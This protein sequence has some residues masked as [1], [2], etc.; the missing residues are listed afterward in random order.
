VSR[1]VTSAPFTSESSSGRRERANVAGHGT[2]STLATVSEPDPYQQLLADLAAEHA[3]LDAVVAPLEAAAW[4]TP[5]PAEGW[6]VAD[7]ISH[8]HFFDAAATRAAVD[9][10]G[11]QREVEQAL[12]DP[13]YVDK[14]LAAGRGTAP[15]ELL[16]SW[17]AGRA[18]MLDVFGGLDGKARLPWYGPPMSAMSFA[19]ARLMETWAHGQDVVDAVGAERTPTDRLRHVAHLGVRTRGFSYVVRGLEPP[20]DDVRV[21]LV[22]PSG[23][24]WTW[25]PEQAEQRVTGP[26]LDLCLLVTQRRHRDDL[27]LVADG[28]I[29]DEWLDL[30]QAF[31]GG[32]GTGRAALGA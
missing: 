26:A 12:T 25:G 15:D 32:P 17:R 6:D 27:A 30:A 11:F 5:T 13:D 1:P 19:T 7:T 22:A 2:R 16:A 21:E 3:D 4:A 24:T 31:A 18:A 14:E 28:L 29:A 8:L 9:P 20:E 10:D 23:E